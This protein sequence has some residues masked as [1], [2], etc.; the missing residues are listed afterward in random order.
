MDHYGLSSPVAVYTQDNTGYLLQG[1]NNGIMT[2]LDGKTGEALDR[3]SLGGTTVGT[4]AVMN[5]M[6]VV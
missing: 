3:V 5:D 1:N 2:L 4:P 6:L